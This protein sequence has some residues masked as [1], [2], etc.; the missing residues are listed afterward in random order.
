VSAGATEQGQVADGRGAQSG[1]K[2]PEL[3]ASSLPH[4]ERAALTYGILDGEAWL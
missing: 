2:D 1:I 4:Y 3:L